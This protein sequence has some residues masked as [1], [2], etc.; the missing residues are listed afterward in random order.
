MVPVARLMGKVLTGYAGSF[1]RRYRRHGHLFQN[2][3]KSI[4][5]E[6]DPY[7]QEL[8]RYIHL[9]PLRAGL[10][11][12]LEQLE[13]YPY[14]GHSVLAGR[15]KSDW[16]DREYV[17][18]CFDR[19]EGEA[20][21]KYLLFVSEG[22]EKGS[23]P[24]LA[25]GGIIRSAGGWREYKKLRGSGVRLKGDERI[26]GGSEFVE[27]V[28]RETEEQWTKKTLLKKRGVDLGRVI[29]KTAAHFGMEPEEL[30]SGNRSRGIA[31]ARAVVCFLAVRRLGLTCAEVAKELNVS[32]SAVS[33][34][35]MRGRKGLKADSL[36][37][38][39]LKS[40]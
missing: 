31:R 23:R 18:S 39:I 5:C 26:L 3:Y 19:T 12:D 34:S 17:L 36:E 28:L 30:T 24:E 6:E 14:S 1:N 40:Q 32:P 25:G 10:V 11:K 33:R 8:V 20:R 13:D 38:Q 4:L 22:A 7:L 16:Q 29:E 21:K 15:R 35:I 2:R 27:R 9:N 37:E